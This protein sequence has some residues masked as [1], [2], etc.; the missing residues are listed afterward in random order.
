LTLK[1]YIYP[2]LIANVNLPEFATDLYLSKFPKNIATDGIYTLYDT[3]KN[4]TFSA[5]NCN[6]YA[7]EYRLRFKI[8]SNDAKKRDDLGNRV[9]SE[10]LGMEDDYLRQ[11][12][13][14]NDNS[15]FNE[16]TDWYE[17]DIDFN[18]YI[19]N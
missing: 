11:I 14:V 15:F 8:V 18:I 17:W 7:F 1:E 13:F 12:N 9:I 16:F 4:S 5:M 3:S 10:V 6:N 19:D 2:L